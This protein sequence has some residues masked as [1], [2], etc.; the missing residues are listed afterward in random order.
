VHARRGVSRAAVL[1]DQAP[2]LRQ[3]GQRDAD[4]LSL[5]DEHAPSPDP[6][7]CCA[8]KEDARFRPPDA[9]VRVV[10]RSA[11]AT[12]EPQSSRRTLTSRLL[13]PADASVKRPRDLAPGPRPSGES[14]RPRAPLAPLPPSGGTVG[15]DHHAV[16][17]RTD[18]LLR[19]SGGLIV[20]V[21]TAWLVGTDESE[22]VS[23]SAPLTMSSS[24][25]HDSP[26]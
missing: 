22:P 14:A 17:P 8:R 7:W 20:A 12:D 11:I 4:L 26:R 10:A 5:V 24:R 25:S 9:R 21:R 18:R 23:V 6:E 13:C 16:R 19:E 2:A 3:N 15:R 1:P